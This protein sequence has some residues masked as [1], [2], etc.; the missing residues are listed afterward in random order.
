MSGQMWKTVETKAREGGVA[1]AEERRE[2]RKSGKEMKEK[3]RKK[4][5]QK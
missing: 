3:G 5:Q 1:K 2:E 4:K